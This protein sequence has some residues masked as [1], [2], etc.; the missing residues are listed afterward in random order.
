MGMFRYPKALIDVYVM[1]LEEGGSSLATAITAAAAA[2]AD[3]GIEMVDMVIGATVGVHRPLSDEPADA[4]IVDPTV[5][6]EVIL[7]GAVTVA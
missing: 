2:L 1:V 4:L 3:A 6:E 7:S 5:V